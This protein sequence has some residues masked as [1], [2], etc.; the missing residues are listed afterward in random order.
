MDGLRYRVVVAVQRKRTGNKKTEVKAMK[1]PTLVQQILSD[2]S[3]FTGRLLAENPDDLSIEIAAPTV[4]SARDYF[5][6]NPLHDLTGKIVLSNSTLDMTVEL[7]PIMPVAGVFFRH[8]EQG[9]SPASFVWPSCMQE[10]ARL[11]YLKKRDGAYWR[12]GLND[13]GYIEGPVGTSDKDPVAG[14]RVTFLGPIQVYSSAIQPC[15]ATRVILPIDDKGQPSI[16]ALLKNAKGGR[17]KAETVDVSRRYSRDAD[18]MPNPVWR[19]IAA[20]ASEAFSE[21]LLTDEFDIAHKVLGDYWFCLRAS[22]PQC[23]VSVLLELRWDENTSTARGRKIDD[24]M[25]GRASF[26]PA[27]ARL[28]WTKITEQASAIAI[29]LSTPR[30]GALEHVTITN[31]VDAISSTTQFAKLTTRVPERTPAWRRQN[32][33]S[34]EGYVCPV[35]TPES[36]KVGLSL[37]LAR[38]AKVEPGTGRFVHQEISNSP[39]DVLGHGASLVPFFH[40]NDGAR[41]MMAAKNLR[42][43]VPIAVPDVPLV[44]TTGERVVLASADDLISIGACP[45]CQRDNKLALGKNL[46][47]AY[48]PW[49]GFNSDDALVIGRHVCESGDF[50]YVLTQTYS[51]NIPAGYTMDETTSAQDGSVLGPRDVV[52]RFVHESGMRA[53]LLIRCAS[54]HPVVLRRKALSAVTGNPL[55]SAKFTYETELR[56]PL[57]LGDKLMGRH[58]NKGVIG[59]IEDAMPKLPIDPRL[60]DFSGRTID[61]LINPHGVISRMNIGQL[62]E[63]HLGWALARGVTPDRL[64][65]HGKDPHTLAE[66]FSDALDLK[67]LGARLAE[68][69]LDEFGRSPL[70]LTDDFR[71]QSPVLVGV[72]HIVRLKHIPALKAQARG[73]GKDH[74]YSPA[75][76]QASHGIAYGGGQRIGEMEMW[77]LAA[78]RAEANLS[79]IFGQK[80]SKDLSSGTFSDRMSDYL[81]AIRIRCSENVEKSVKLSFLTDEDVLASAKGQ[82]TNE[83]LPSVLETYRHRCLAK[84]CTYS[85]GGEHFRLGSPRFGEALQQLGFHAGPL[86]AQG[87]AFVFDLIRDDENGNPVHKT[88]HF[89]PKEGTAADTLMAKVVSKDKQMTGLPACLHE[90][91]LIGRFAARKGEP[92]AGGKKKN[93][94]KEGLLFALQVAEGSRSLCD[95][96]LTCPSHPSRPLTPFGKSDT[97]F[98]GAKGSFYDETTFGQIDGALAGKRSGWG[99][100]RLPVSIKY[101]SDVFQGD[102]APDKGADMP[103]M[104]LLPVPPLCYRLPRM[105]SGRA[106]DTNL[107][108]KGYGPALR[109]CKNWDKLVEKKGSETAELI[110]TR[111]V[112]RV[113][114]I[115]RDQLVGKDGLIRHAGLGRRV[116][117]SSRLVIVPDP[118]MK[119]DEISLPLPAF[120]ELFRNELASFSSKNLSQDSQ[121]LDWREVLNLTAWRFS[122]SK[123]D[124]AVFEQYDS[125]CRRFLQKNSELRV[126]LNRQPTLHRYSMQAFR[127]R[128]NDDPRDF[129]L[130]VHP[131]CCAGFNADFDGDEMA[132]HRPLSPAAQREAAAMSPT[133]NLLSLATGHPTCSYDQD[134]VLGTFHLLRKEFRLHDQFVSLLP[135]DLR[136]MACGSVGTAKDVG[137]KILEALCRKPP[138]EDAARIVTEWHRLAVQACTEAGVSF[139]AEEL[140]HLALLMPAKKDLTDNTVTLALAKGLLQ[141]AVSKG[142]GSPGYHFAAMALSGARKEKQVPQILVSRGT[143]DPGG[144]DFEVPP[145]KMRFTRSLLDGMPVREFMA[146]ALNTR[147]SMCDKNLGTAAA[148]Y[149]TRKLVMACF[150]AVI[151]RDCGKKS[152]VLGCAIHGSVC[153]ACFKALPD[154]TVPEVGFPIGLVAAQSIGERGTQLSMQS[155]HTGHRA[156]STRE[157]IALFENAATLLVC[158]QPGCASQLLVDSRDY[159]T[160]KPLQCV[161]HKKVM[162]NLTPSNWYADGQH[163]LFLKVLHGLDAYHSLDIRHLLLVWKIISQN[164]GSLKEVLRTLD[165]ASALGFERQAQGLLHAASSG[166]SI[167]VRHPA[168]RLLFFDGKPGHLRLFDQGDEE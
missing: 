144:T 99:Y 166:K 162:A 62:L 96:Q 119:W 163:D 70:V 20:R 6:T 140:G 142:P 135:E 95:L 66:P 44:S 75:T 88:L 131:L 141:T 120:V 24:L 11:R 54:P 2:M 154:G 168:G 56:L 134:F 42:Q 132:I 23:L 7:C 155:F 32:H 33:P 1:P 40:H 97:C 10:A 137:Q 71:T 110:L 147:S 34:F 103:T 127:M 80:S 50:D 8:G 58:G 115:I 37:F 49:Y 112:A 45:P 16:S 15:L 5:K 160:N 152:D 149:L 145:E 79:E 51:R 118:S 69:G 39:A 63:T 102:K 159:D 3:D 133:K 35:Q 106:V 47:V 25:S 146:S 143:L 67:A 150:P 60:G 72:Q 101:P 104:S 129:V 158:P 61:L 28:A 114:R 138:A 111:A 30:A 98:G 125:I 156:I 136:T 123:G 148:G 43:A 105:S 81:H 84:T 74:L 22:L 46:L 59:K 130:K 41:N 122:S 126:I 157:I 26:D 19:S 31:P 21:K 100:I 113:F 83:R 53:P 94:S 65:K 87:L 91:T 55:A 18:R 90:F 92:T 27:I 167:S 116:D 109:I 4:A 165:S 164:G 121:P 108:R 29:A 48:L 82:V 76:G 52:A 78:H 85:F 73:Q 17:R 38:G 93:V 117:L 89:L 153:T 128:I 139:G 57:A 77:A 13:G 64:V 12:L 151:H 107:V 9:I 86:K 68:T 124:P 36:K 14:R 161:K